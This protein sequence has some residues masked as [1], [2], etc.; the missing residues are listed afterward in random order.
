MK[1]AAMAGAMAKPA[2][3]K[4]PVKSAAIVMNPRISSST[5]P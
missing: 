4:T 1:P 2:T 5:E 3:A